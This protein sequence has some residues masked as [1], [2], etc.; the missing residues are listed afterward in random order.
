MQLKTYDINYLSE[1]GCI[2]LVLYSKGSALLG[3]L[4]P[5]LENSSG[6]YPV[7]IEVCNSIVKTV[8]D[9]VT[10]NIPVNKVIFLRLD[11]VELKGIAVSMDQEYS[12]LRSKLKMKYS[13]VPLVDLANTPRI[14]EYGGLSAEGGS[15]ARRVE[16]K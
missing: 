9:G 6:L 7:L 2:P 1:R 12:L 10:L 4:L 13:D 8:S 5:K 15:R 11:S 16:E 14:H 3:H